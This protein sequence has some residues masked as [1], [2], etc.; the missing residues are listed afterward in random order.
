MMMF[1]EYAK[2]LPPEIAGS[3]VPLILQNLDLPGI[4]EFLERLYLETGQ[5]P[6]PSDPAVREAVD[7]RKQAEEQKAAEERELQVRRVMADILQKEARAR[8]IGGPDIEHTMAQTAETLAGITGQ[9][10]KRQLEALVAKARLAT[11]E[12][13][14]RTLAE[15]LRRDVEQGPARERLTSARRG[16]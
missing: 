14:V 5:G 15:T 16:G 13:R 4:D 9:E 1:M 12:G 11:E 8:K 10:W 7:A 2:S 6:E 3:L